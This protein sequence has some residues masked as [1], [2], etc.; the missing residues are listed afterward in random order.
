MIVTVASFKGGVGKTTTA[1]H[2]AA[3]LN[4]LRPTCLLDG[5]VTRNVTAW[6]EREPN[7]GGG[8]PFPVAPIE[9]LGKMARLYEHVVIDTGQRPSEDDMQAAA[10]GCDLLVVPAV[11]A[12][13]DTDGLGQT[14]RALQ[15][16][17][18]ARYKVLLTKVAPH[19]AGD[20]ASL[21]ELLAGIQ[22]PVFRSEIPLL[23]AYDKAAGMGRIVRD[24]DDRQAD[25]AWEA[26]TAAGREL[27]V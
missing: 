13:L 7:A 10:G 6:S 17:P 2:L 4:G 27:H 15:M 9:H 20:A 25:R 8:F 12:A 1:V 14:L 22:A 11:P 18:R 24:A 19:S 3:Y 5:D 26:Y 21:R 23:K 16:I